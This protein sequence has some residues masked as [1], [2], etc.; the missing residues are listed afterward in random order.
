M[1]KLTARLEFVGRWSEDIEVEVPEGADA[2]EATRLL[3]AAAEAHHP[4][5]PDDHDIEME[6]ADWRHSPEFAPSGPDEPPAH[7]WVEQS[8]RRWATD[9]Y[10]VIREDCPRPTKAEFDLWRAGPHDLSKL[11]LPRSETGEALPGDRQLPKEGVITKDRLA[12]QGPLLAL[13]DH[14]FSAHCVHIW[15]PG[16]ETP[17]AIVALCRAD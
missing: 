1:P 16:E 11:I 5:G 4:D 6:D 12:R 3:S 2:I 15:R 8:G 17:I 10:I 14:T 7:V 13:G 9:G